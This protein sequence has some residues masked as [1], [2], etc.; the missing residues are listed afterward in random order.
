MAQITQNLWLG[1]DLDQCQLPSLDVPPNLRAI[2]AATRRVL[3]LSPVSPPMVGPGA[4]NEQPSMEMLH[5]KPALKPFL[6]NIC[7]PWEGCMELLRGPLLSWQ[8][9]PHS[10]SQFPSLSSGLVIVVH[11]PG[12]LGDEVRSPG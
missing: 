12:L 5:W 10:E 11:L 1:Q 9:V 6:L 7:S 4:D 8:Q 3:L 2:P